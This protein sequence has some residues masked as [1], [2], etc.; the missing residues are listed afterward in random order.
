M[1][2]SDASEVVHT[3]HFAKLPD[4]PPVEICS[5]AVLYAILV[6]SGFPPLCFLMSQIMEIARNS[7][8]H[9]FL[10]LSK[11]FPCQV[12]LDEE[13]GRYRRGSLVE[14]AE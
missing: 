6:S 5:C 4:V 10:H 9:I 2:G 12:D 7:T 1:L 3:F 13:P 11:Y 8:L 14:L